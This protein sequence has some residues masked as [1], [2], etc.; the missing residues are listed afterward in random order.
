MDAPGYI[1]PEAQ[2]F[3]LSD[4]TKDIINYVA[5]ESNTVHLAPYQYNPAFPA[6]GE[7]YGLNKRLLINLAIKYRPFQQPAPLD[8]YLNVICLINTASPYSYLSGE[9]I[10]AL[11]GCETSPSVI[12]AFVH[13]NWVIEC[14][15]SPSTSKFAN[16]NVL[17]MDFL[18]KN[19]LSIFINYCDNKFTLVK[20]QQ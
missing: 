17:G 3:D 4:I 6:E 2:N 15:Q 1:A 9:T 11:V 14:H 10:K 12:N 5:R 19:K 16:V 20:T 8:H 13:S 18:S 7:I